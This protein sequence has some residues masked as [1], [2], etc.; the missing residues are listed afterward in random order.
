MDPAPYNPLDRINL[1]RSVELTLLQQSCQPMPLEEFFNG[2]GVYALYYHGSLAS[3]RR[4]AS[5]E[6]RVPIYVGKAVPAGS[7]RG[8]VDL[9]ATIGPVLY[10]RISDHSES[11]ESARNLSIKDFSVRY[12]VVDDIF[13]AMGEALMIQQFRPL[14][15]VVV[16][17]FGLHDPGAR[18]PWE[19]AIGLGRAASG[20]SMARENE[21][22]PNRNRHPGSHQR[23]LQG[24][25]DRN[26]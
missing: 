13:I 7:R 11:I 26:K 1:A 6:C 22:V 15:N 18:P 19:Q 14:W 16:S 21:A 12:L 3:Y 9:S 20:A 2:A 17:G 25:R 4:I 23:S 8:L 10:N 24:R 5:P